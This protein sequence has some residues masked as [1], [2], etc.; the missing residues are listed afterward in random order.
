[1]HTLTPRRVL[2]LEDEMNNS[3]VLRTPALL[4]ARRT[5]SLASFA[6]APKVEPVHEDVRAMS[7]VTVELR[8][9]AGT[10]AAIG[11]A[12]SH[13]L[14][15]DRPEGKAGGMGLGFN[16]AQ[17]LALTIGGCFC[18]DLRY[19]A[20]EM[21]L[22]IRNLAVSVT[23]Q[24]EGHPLLT[25]SAAMSVACELI[26]GSDSSLLIEKA[27]ESCMVSNSLRKGFSVVIEAAPA[28]TAPA[29]Q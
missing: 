21:G 6:L 7:L 2:I 28:N 15:V 29:E 26:D 27:R 8:N 16:G 24:M 23:V 19:V 1:M 13:T 10:E 9:V 5:S 22:G 4:P 20:Q 14:I 11:W 25:T 17:M 12:G 18:N 3:S